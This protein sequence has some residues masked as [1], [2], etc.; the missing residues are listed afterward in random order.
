[1]LVTNMNPTIKEGADSSIAVAVEF[2]S[3]NAAD[4]FYHSDE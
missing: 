1:M 3:L 4:T 2:E